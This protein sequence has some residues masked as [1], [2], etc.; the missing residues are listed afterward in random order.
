MTREEL[1]QR[2]RDIL[3]TQWS[4]REGKDVPDE[5]GV[6]FLQDGVELD[7][8]VLYADIAGSSK[9]V[10]TNSRSF[11]A[12]VVKCFLL[13][14]TKIIHCN[15]GWMT[16][17]DGDRVMAVFVTGAKNTN[18]LKTA[19]QINWA[20]KNV[21]QTQI[22]SFYS[23]SHADFSL[24]H[25]VGVDTSKVLAVRAGQRESS[26]LVWIGDA[27]NFAARLSELREEGYTS[28]ASQ[29]VYDAALDIATK[30]GIYEQDMW[31][32]RQLDW[33]GAKRTVYRSHW[34]WSL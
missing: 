8:T 18:A 16:S 31:E 11:V 13:C 15:G 32:A 10:A 27:P 12:E 3:R 2:V 28:Y 6:R 9:L 1:E 33:N 23:N 19:L 17:F 21:I 22:R 5:A 4:T 34:S 25:A 29:A 7:A 14:S 30:G 24:G 20:V 26:D